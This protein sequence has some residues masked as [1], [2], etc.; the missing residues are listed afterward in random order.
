MNTVDKFEKLTISIDEM[1]TM[2]AIGKSKAYELSRQKGFPVLQLGRRKLIPL[3]GLK[4][5][6]NNN[7]S[8]V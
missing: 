7:S 6:I 8:I 1:A 4:T 2:L 3:E 5:F